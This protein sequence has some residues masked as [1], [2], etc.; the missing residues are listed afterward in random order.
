MDLTED[1]AFGTGE[2]QFFNVKSI[3]VGKLSD[4]KQNGF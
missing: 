2:G 1:P 3:K 4:Q